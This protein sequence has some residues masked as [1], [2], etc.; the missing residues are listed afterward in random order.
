MSPKIPSE[1]KIFVWGLAALA[2]LMTS[3]VFSS[4]TYAN[5]NNG[6]QQA[7]AKLAMQKAKK[8]DSGMILVR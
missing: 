1:S 5:A 8:P 2:L 6:A 7:K 3:V 4:L